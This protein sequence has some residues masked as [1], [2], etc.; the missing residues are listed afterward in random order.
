MKE[1]SNVN[2]TKRRWGKYVAVLLAFIVSLG[3][4]GYFLVEKTSFFS[5]KTVDVIGN[6]KLKKDRVLLY[7]GVAIGDSIMELNEDE[8]LMNLKS[9]PYIESV[10]IEKK[11]PNRIVLK[12][13]EK[14]DVLVVVGDKKVYIDREGTVLS[15]SDSLKSYYVPPVEGLKLKSPV[16]SNGLE[17][18][19]KIDKDEFKD[20]V[21]GI[22]R[23]GLFGEIS[24][25][26]VTEKDELEIHFGSKKEAL[27]GEF[28]D[29]EYKLNYLEE[30]TKDLSKKGKVFEKIDFTRGNRVIVEEKLVKEGD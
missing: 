19:N 5:I 10:N 2:E 23:L 13:V 16:V 15:I 22:G 1:I 12:I 30:I 8:I 14:K 26:K 24:N 6:E 9:E 21:R 18:S 3:I 4:T 7:S 28:K 29:M 25:I 27:L 11:Y 17:Y 20:F